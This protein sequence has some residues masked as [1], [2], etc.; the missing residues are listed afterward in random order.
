MAGFSDNLQVSFSFL[1][2]QYIYSVLTTVVATLYAF[3]DKYPDIWIYARGSTKA[4]TRLY[5]MGI[6]KF[7]S[8]V[9]SDFEVLG[10]RN[11][12]WEAFKNNVEYQGFW[13]DGK[14]NN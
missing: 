3:T 11:D 9:T 10:E 4:R 14:R 5:R 12:D 1:P 7:L 13:S 6:T 8:E 2:S